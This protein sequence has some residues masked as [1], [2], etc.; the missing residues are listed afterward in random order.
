LLKE[1]PAYRMLAIDTSTRAHARNAAGGTLSIQRKS[2]HPAVLARA[3][4]RVRVGGGAIERLGISHGRGL[5]DEPAAGVA[6]EGGGANGLLPVSGLR[7]R[8]FLGHVGVRV[9]GFVWQTVHAKAWEAT[10][11]QGTICEGTALWTAAGKVKY[12]LADHN[13]LGGDGIADAFGHGQQKGG[14]GNATL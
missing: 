11:S 3:L 1:T 10:C 12:D 4:Q 8:G 13:R 2:T 5:V 6:G 7:G 9:L 14:S